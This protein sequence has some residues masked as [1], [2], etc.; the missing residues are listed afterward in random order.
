[1]AQAVAD[2]VEQLSELPPFPKVT[3]KLLQLLDDPSVSI[4]G[5]A[6]IISSDPSLVVK[7]IHIA[8]SPF[9]M[10]S[11]EITSVK[12]AVFVLG[13]TTIKSIT[14][15]ISIQKGFSRFQ[16]RPDTFDQYRFWAHS[17]ATA[18][19][20]SKIL[21]TQSRQAADRYYLVGLIHDIGKLIQA[22]FWPDSWVTIIRHLQTNGGSY[23]DAELLT[24]STPHS[25][26]TS[27]LCRNWGFPEDLLSALDPS[28]ASANDTGQIR[29][30]TGVLQAANAIADEAGYPFPPEERAEHES[31]DLEP[32]QAIVT[33]LDTDVRHQL[34]TLTS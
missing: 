22:N 32:F 18:I 2:V 3:T 25:T 9:Y 26:L 34:T 28:S 21:N 4:D 31:V 27:Q 24:F 11:K 17:Y 20:A 1:M 12:D 6:Q 14:T 5:L 29:L 16:P 23:E 13:I 19:A 30:D 10:C 7:V 15:A 8:N 33:T